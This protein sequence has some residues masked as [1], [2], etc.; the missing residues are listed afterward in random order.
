VFQITHPQ[1]SPEKAVVDAWVRADMV[2]DLTAGAHAYGD[3]VQIAQKEG[4]RILR[5][6][7]T[8]ENLRRLFPLE[9]VRHRV[10]AGAAIM[11]QSNTMRITSPFGT[12]LTLYKEGRIG[13]MNYSIADKPGR[14]DIWPSGM[15][16]CAPIEDMGE[17]V[18]V[19]A[20]GDVMLA[21]GQYVREKVTMEVKDGCITKIW[22]GLEADFLRNDYFARF[23]DP[24]AYRISHVGWG[25]EKRADWLKFGQDNECYYGNMQIAFG[26]NVGVFIQGRTRCKAHMDFP[27]RFNSYWCDDTQI[28]SEGQFLIDELK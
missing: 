10:I 20:P 14:W 1:N 17:G 23:N 19:L 7:D 26:A 28:M 3:I 5:V 18:L 11:G 27:C 21:T 12:D 15:V 13:A 4:T 25:C 24:N 8:P 6:A 16:N 22:G 2:I 9:E